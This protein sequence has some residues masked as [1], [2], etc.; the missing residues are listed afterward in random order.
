[1]QTIPHSVRDIDDPNLVLQCIERNLVI[2]AEAVDER[3]AWQTSFTLSLQQQLLSQIRDLR[4]R[5]GRL[6]HAR[7]GREHEESYINED[8]R[9]V[10]QSDT[11]ST[12]S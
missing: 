9:T 1:M 12:K 2:W 10:P 8:L 5:R 6:E 4:E 7:R 3:V 11:R